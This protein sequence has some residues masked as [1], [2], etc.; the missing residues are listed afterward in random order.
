MPMANRKQRAQIANETVEILDRESY[1]FGGA[2]VSLSAALDDMQTGTVLYGPADLDL[3]IDSMDQPQ[4]RESTVSVCNCTTFAAARSL[5]DAGYQNPLCL[6]F[7]SAKN[8]GGGFLSGSQAQEECLARA[9]GLYKSLASQM[10][11]YDANRSHPSALYTNHIIYSPRVPV[12]RS[13]DDVLIGEPYFV[14]VVTSPAVNAGAVRKNEPSNVQSIRSTMETRIRSVLAV[15]RQHDHN[16]VVLGAWGCGVF[17]NDPSDVAHWF[18]DALLGDSR[19]AGAF[20]RIV[21]GVL[22]FADDTPTYEAFRHVFA[23]ESHRTRP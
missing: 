15:A 17:G 7:G 4:R 14:S 12:F 10:T 5:I 6:N 9:S 21:F 3:L 8:P 19:F 23:E 20:D 13:D 2:T 16:A 11:Y 1:V 18:A 22:D